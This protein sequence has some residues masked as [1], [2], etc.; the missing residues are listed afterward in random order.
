MYGKLFKIITKP[1][2]KNEL[3]K[4]LRED[5]AV[6]RDTEPGTLRFDV[7]D[8]P[9]HPDAVYVYEAYTNLKAFEKHQANE[10]YKRFVDQI[11]P[12]LIGEQSTFFGWTDSLVSN[13]D[14]VTDDP[15]ISKVSF[16]SF[17][18]DVENLR[19]FN[20]RAELR[21]LAPDRKASVAHVH[22]PPG[23]RTD[24]HHHG[25]VQLLWFIDGEGEVTLDNEKTL[26][27]RA[28]DIVRVAAGSRHWHGASA[29]H[30]AT[31]IAITV[32]ETTWDGR[33]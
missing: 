5:A 33:P 1:G 10:P 31:H 9:G 21:R 28:G 15:D 20:G 17:P 8:V 18:P 22:F 32:G 11:G 16:G 19:H 3:V 6:A 25:G 7:W 29:E 24:W 14:P 12:E 4:F 27:C 26:S 13:T 30:D 2:G 23:V